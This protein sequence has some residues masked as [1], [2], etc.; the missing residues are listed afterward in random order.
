MAGVAGETF[1]LG[2]IKKTQRHLEPLR[3]N[4]LQHR[5]QYIINKI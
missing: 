5:H 2:E 1:G 3:Y 4:L